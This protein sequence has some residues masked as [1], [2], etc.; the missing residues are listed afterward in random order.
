MGFII[1]PS[2][3]NRVMSS[4]RSAILAIC[5]ALIG[6]FL[7]IFFIKGNLFLRCFPEGDEMVEL[8]LLVSPDLKNQRI[9]SSV[10]PTCGAKLFRDFAPVTQ[11]IP[12]TKDLLRISKS[13]SSFTI[14]TQ[15]PV[16]TRVKVE[17]Q[18]GITLIPHSMSR[19][20][21]LPGW[22]P[23]APAQNTWITQIKYSY[24]Y[25]GMITAVLV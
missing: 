13:D 25:R 9:R 3:K 2:V 22:I 20:A 18:A 24:N 17:S 1:F 5:S 8:S 6:F 23:K 10:H 16:F 7:S 15:L 19:Y 21:T 4:P 11:K 14:F 12:M